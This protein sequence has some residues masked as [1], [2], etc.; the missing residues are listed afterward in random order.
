M[1]VQFCTLC[2]C[3]SL[4]SSIFN[5]LH[6]FTSSN[7]LDFHWR[8]LLK[9]IEKTKIIKREF[10]QPFLS[11]FHVCIIFS[12]PE[13]IEVCFSFPQGIIFPHVLGTFI[14]Y[15]S[16]ILLKDSHLGFFISFLNHQSFPFIWF[17]FICLQTQ[18][19][20]ILNKLFWI[21]H[22]A[23]AAKLYFFAFC[24]Q[25][26]PKSFFYTLSPIFHL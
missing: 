9:F 2:C 3:F 14:P 12:V 23:V 4:V 16:P 7:F 10:H 17:I 26:S 6:G 1:P 21:P 5:M 11:N 22:T 8:L 15:Q 19:S 18:L 13:I 24:S 25:T 20:P